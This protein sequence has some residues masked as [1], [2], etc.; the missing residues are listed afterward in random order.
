MDR[1]G[2]F[3]EAVYRKYARPEFLHTDPLT[4]VRRYEDPADRETVAF[5]VALI[6][7]GRVRSI[8]EHAEDLLRLFGDEPARYVRDFDPERELPRLHPLRYRFHTGRDLAAVAAA[9]RLAIDRHGSL[10]RFFLDGGGDVRTRI[11]R[12][13]RRLLESA[14]GAIPAGPD[15]GVS[16]GLRFLLA[17][18]EKG[19]ACKRWNLFLRWMVRRDDGIDL[20]L[21]SGTDPAELIV[22]LDVHLLRIGGRLG[23]VTGRAANWNAAERLTGSLRRWDRRDPLRFDFPICRLGILDRCPAEGFR[24]ECRACEIF[25]FC[26]NF[27]KEVGKKIR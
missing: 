3:L 9:L 17:S 16:R 22:P 14:T 13:S 1:T 12:M 6:A 4:V 19:G 23:F 26:E 27:S 11:A 25:P 24:A 2:R 21:W 18:P 20:G 15:R 7:Y 8:R 10:E 5:F